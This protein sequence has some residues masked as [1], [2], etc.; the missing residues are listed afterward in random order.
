VDDDR[1]CAAFLRLF[2]TDEGH[3]VRSAVSGKD[4]LQA[5]GVM[6]PDLLITD[7]LLKDGTD[8]L[9]LARNLRK[10]RPELSIIFI[11]GMPERELQNEVNKLGHAHI[12]E[13]PLDLDRLLPMV[14]TLVGG[15]AGSPAP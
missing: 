2:L 3:E 7:W 5:A 9:G 4:A 1:N 10:D 6:A 11:T 13:K 15:G 8:G 12:F 14:T